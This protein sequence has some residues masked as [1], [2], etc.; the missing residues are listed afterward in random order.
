[1]EHWV[2]YLAHKSVCDTRVDLFIV[3][4]QNSPI[5]LVDFPLPFVTLLFRMAYSQETLKRLLALTIVAELSILD[6]V[7]GEPLGKTRK[8]K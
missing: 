6:D 4:I 3:I 5:F 8:Q 1:M 7:L 2:K